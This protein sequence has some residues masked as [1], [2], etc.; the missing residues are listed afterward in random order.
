MAYVYPES[1]FPGVWESLSRLVR[2]GRILAPVEVSGEILWPES[3]RKWC[4]ANKAM[5][6][7][8][9]NSAWEIALQVTERFPKLVKSNT[10]TEQAD[11][12]VIA[13][14]VV[15]KDKLSK[16]EPMIIAHEDPDKPNK[17]PSVAK[18]FGVESDRITRLFF[19]EGWKF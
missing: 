8:I 3:L 12:F 5:F 19:I 7:P 2:S 13:L 10:P 9:K 1:V 15:L 17:I 16:D 14:S 6:L 4:D 11:P 18:S